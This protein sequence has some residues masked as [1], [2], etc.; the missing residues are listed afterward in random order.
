[1]S[2]ARSLKVWDPLVR[3]GHWTVVITFFTAYLTGDEFAQL[4][5]WSGYLLG[6]VICVRIVWGFVGPVHA[7]FRDFVRGP[8]KTLRYL[9]DLVRG[10]DSRYIGHNPAGGAMVVA[11]LLCLTATVVSGLVLLAVEDGQGPLAGWVAAAPHE[12]APR[13]A[14]EAGA[15]RRSTPDQS[16]HGAAYFWEETHE[17]LANLTLLLVALHI[18][19]VIHASRA[20]R[21]NLIRSMITGRKRPSGESDPGASPT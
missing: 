16:E 19:G 13:P 12:R 2:Y 11:M 1:M 6:S 14:D 8:R 18:L 10:R 3:V 20:H 7:R 15:G 5:L 9:G 21:E 17:V 4:H